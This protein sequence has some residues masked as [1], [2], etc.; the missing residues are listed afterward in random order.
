MG[1]YG[2]P[3]ISAAVDR[4]DPFCEI[5]GDGIGSAGD[6]AVLCIVGLEHSRARSPNTE[7][8]PP[9]GAVGTNGALLNWTEYVGHGSPQKA[10]RIVNRDH[11]LGRLV[12]YNIIDDLFR[13]TRGATG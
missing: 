7:D 9:S 13:R 4:E 10:K 5:S 1:L 12:A 11:R 6:L 8:S 3:K 2:Q